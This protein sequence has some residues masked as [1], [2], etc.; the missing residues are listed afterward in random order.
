ML[1]DIGNFFN[2]IWTNYIEFMTKIFG[3]SLA[4]GITVVA[5][6]VIICLIFLG[7][8]NNRK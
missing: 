2:S 5:A 8:I 3:H 6:F 1:K 7:L 4:I